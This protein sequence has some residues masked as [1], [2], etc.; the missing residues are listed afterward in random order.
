MLEGAGLRTCFEPVIRRHA[1]RRGRIGQ[2]PAARA[3]ARLRERAPR[4]PP[5]VTGNS[6]P[7]SAI[8]KTTDRRPPADG[9]GG[10]TEDRSDKGKP[11]ERRRRK[12]T[13][14][15]PSGI[16]SPGRRRHLSG[17]ESAALIRC[18]CRACLCP[19]PNSAER[20]SWPSSRSMRAVA[21]HAPVR[22]AQR[23]SAGW[24]P[25][26]PSPVLRSHGRSRPGSRYPNP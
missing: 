2:V 14:L 17:S 15:R 4:Q 26:S 18:G 13:G 23:V 9:S 16:R 11:A 25:S 7:E 12:A 22:Q 1:G 3:L 6:V 5:A 19:G 20:S 21:Q 10:T 24:P 8:H